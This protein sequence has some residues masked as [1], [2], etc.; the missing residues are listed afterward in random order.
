MDEDFDFIAEHPKA[1]MSKVDVIRVN[2]KEYLAADKV[3]EII[4]ARIKLLEDIEQGGYNHLS[5]YVAGATANDHR[6][7]K[8][9][10]EALKGVN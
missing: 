4:D 6:I 8:N 2:D 5:R 9:Q 1:D 3:L 7:V 10:I